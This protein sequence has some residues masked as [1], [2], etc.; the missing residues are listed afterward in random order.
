[1]NVKMR[2]H[3]F[4]RH[5][6][7]SETAPLPDFVP[8]ETPPQKLHPFSVKGWLEGKKAIK[9]NPKRNDP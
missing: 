9:K 4:V 6:D 7:S 5:Q 1:M 2:E 3:L 8:L